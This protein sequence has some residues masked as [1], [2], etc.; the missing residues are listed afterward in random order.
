MACAR[1]RLSP[2]GCSA[3]PAF[4]PSDRTHIPLQSLDCR[5]CSQAPHRDQTSS[6]PL[7][8]ATWRT[9]EIAPSPSSNRLHCRVNAPLPKKT[10]QTNGSAGD[11]LIPSLNASRAITYILHVNVQNAPN[12]PCALNTT[13]LSAQPSRA[14]IGKRG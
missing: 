5:C 1:I 8:V 11:G 2:F 3:D 13:P 9:N 14:P 6:S 10:R 12:L 7:P 4:Q